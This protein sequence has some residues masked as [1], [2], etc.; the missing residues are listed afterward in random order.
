[1]QNIFRKING[2]VSL[3][4]SIVIRLGPLVVGTIS[5]N[6]DDDGF[7]IEGCGG[8]DADDDRLIG[9][10][11]TDECICNTDAGHKSFYDGKLCISVEELDRHSWKVIT[12]TDP[13]PFLPYEQ[14]MLGG[15][16]LSNGAS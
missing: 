15:P 1:M 8:I 7:Y 9:D 13:I 3:A 16:S 11:N 5:C 10:P 12:F 2:S 14:L 4:L 6:D